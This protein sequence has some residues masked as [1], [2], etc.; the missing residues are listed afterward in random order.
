MKKRSKGLVFLAIGFSLLIIAGTWFFLNVF[1]DR[2]AGQRSAEL[3]SLLEANQGEK[4]MPTKGET[5]V[6]RIGND[7]FCGRIVIGSLGI[8]LP[9]YDEWNDRNLK[10]APCRYKGSAEKNDLIISGHNYKSHFGSL[11]LLRKGERITFVDAAE[12]SYNYKVCGLTEVHGTDVAKMQSG[13]WDLT[14]FTCT[15]SGEARL[16]VRCERTEE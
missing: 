8:E 3:L 7:D 1:E 10:S 11:S 14:L 15:L 6:I 4:E 9:V 2:R 5:P 13:N 12:K 16:A